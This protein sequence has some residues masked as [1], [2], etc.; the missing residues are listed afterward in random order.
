MEVELGSTTLRYEIR[1]ET[2]S[3]GITYWA[4]VLTNPDNSS[5]KYYRGL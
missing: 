1:R 4:L 3:G 5:F 2:D